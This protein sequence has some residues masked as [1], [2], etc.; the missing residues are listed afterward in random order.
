VD[1]PREAARWLATVIKADDGVKPHNANQ[2]ICDVVDLLV[3]IGTR[4]EV[5]RVITFSNVS[6]DL[7]NRGYVLRTNLQVQRRILSGRDCWEKMG[8]L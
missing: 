2:M 5:R 6:K 8:I 1:S 7:K 3:Q 4:H